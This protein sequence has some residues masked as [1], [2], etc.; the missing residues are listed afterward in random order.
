MKLVDNGAPPATAPISKHRQKLL[1]NY[2]RVMRLT[3]KAMADMAKHDDRELSIVIENAIW[4][5]KPSTFRC[6]CGLTV[7]QI[8]T[9]GDRWTLEHDGS[10]HTCKRPK[11]KSEPDLYQRTLRRRP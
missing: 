4:E 10:V 1:D 6:G 9:A 8:P 11:P 5:A 3:G 2:A 7:H